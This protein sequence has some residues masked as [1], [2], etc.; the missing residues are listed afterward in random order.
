MYALN[1]EKF[2]WV[3]HEHRVGRRRDASR[4]SHHRFSPAEHDGRRF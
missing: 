4:R 2:L 3:E 1:S